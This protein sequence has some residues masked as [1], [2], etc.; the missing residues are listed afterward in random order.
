MVFAIAR[1]GAPTVPLDMATVIGKTNGTV[2]SYYGIPYAQPPINDLRLRL[3]KPVITYNGTINATVPATQCIQGSA[4][5]RSDLP[6]DILQDLLAY[7]A[8]IPLTAVDV[9]QSEDCL[10]VT[11]QIPAGTK[12][13]AKLPVL[14]YIYGGGFT[15][16]STAGSP[17]DVL[18]QRSV[19]LGQ[20]LVFV[21]IN[22][23][24]AFAFLGGKEIKE[25]GIGNLGLHDQRLALRWIKKHIATFG[26][27]PK[28][29]TING[30][31]AG[32][33]SVGLH[34]VT[35][36]GNNEGLFRAGIMHAGGPLPTGDI[37]IL[38]PFYDTVVAHANCTGAADT[39]ECLRQVPAATLQEAGAAV[40]NL[41]DYPGLAEAWAPRADGVFI[42]APPQHLV[43][44]GSV[45]NIPF[46]TG[47]ALDEGTVF[48]TGSFNVT[49]EDEFRTFV[50]QEF[51]PNTP[52]DVLAPLFDL[53]PN[54]ASE[55]SPF[56]TG[57]ANELYPE[58]K[59]MAALQ[60]DIIFQAP[61]R[62]LLDQRSLKQ[63]A[64]T[65]TSKR[66]AVQGLGCPHGTDAVQALVEGN[67]LAD[68]VI[69]F[70][71]T[72]DPNG[73]ASNRTIPWPRYDPGA[74]SMLVLLE[75]DTPL[76]IVPDTA[77]L[78]AMAGL[79]ALTVAYP[80]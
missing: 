77:R 50:Q 37:E 65:Y 5:P 19:E 62:F 80:I 66:G 59:R 68:Y 41:F 32:A 61:R 60:G 21:S 51:F 72:L 40:P 35:N 10:S 67:D 11:V 6:A 15:S 39:L 34:M 18:V 7:G 73:G 31:S 47:D 45:A 44:A 13:G 70:T 33:I 42:G 14:A 23:R 46:I 64:W 54:V 69:Q 24:L 12:P 16:G 1:T 71:A 29:V 17:G 3:P 57:D 38:Q 22:Y 56:E 20:P 4:A 28:K 78:E 30:P 63:P 55:G 49:T 75:G 8:T 27:D 2:T 25:A 74:R 36:G 9:P 43:L 58:F 53:Y 76:G 26:G 79:T 52:A 48:S